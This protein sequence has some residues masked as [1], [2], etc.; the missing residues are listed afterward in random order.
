MSASFLDPNEYQIIYHMLY[1][2]YDLLKIN[3]VESVHTLPTKRKSDQCRYLVY[4]MIE[5][6]YK[7]Y[8]LMYSEDERFNNNFT[9]YFYLG[10]YNLNQLGLIRNKDNRYLIVQALHY[11]L[12]QTVEYCEE[13]DIFK[14][15]DNFINILCDN[16][17]NKRTSYIDQKP[18]T[19]GP[20]HFLPY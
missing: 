17:K 13:T 4:L 18:Q 20:L 14:L 3:T 11:W 12:Y 5:A 9:E 10:S 15:V 16:D 7:N 19:W 6:N 2:Y 1:E 8:R